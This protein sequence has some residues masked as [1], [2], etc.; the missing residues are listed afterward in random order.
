[1]LLPSVCEALVLMTQCLITFALTSEDEE[2]NF[3]SGD[4]PKDF[5]NAAMVGEGVG[6]P[7]MVISAFS[8]PM[9]RA[10]LGVNDF[11]TRPVEKIRQVVAEG[12]VWKARGFIHASTS[13]RG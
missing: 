13:P 11:P 4:N 1:M 7:E 2:F 10:N 12:D 6:I 8:N 3:P 5:L 9:L